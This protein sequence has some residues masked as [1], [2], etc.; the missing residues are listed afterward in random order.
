MCLTCTCIPLTLALPA[1]SSQLLSVLPTGWCLQI[2]MGW[3][4]TLVVAGITAGILAA[5]FVYSPNKLSADDRVFANRL[6]NQVCVAS[7]VLCYVA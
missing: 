4:L 6:L 2:V 5:V 3:I 1:I 7:L